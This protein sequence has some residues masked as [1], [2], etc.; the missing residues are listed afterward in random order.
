MRKEE[1]DQCHT[2]LARMGCMNGWINR[3][4][5]LM[6]ER[7]GRETRKEVLEVVLEKDNDILN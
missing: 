2:I 1:S 3:N 5:F 7:L 6:L 4:V